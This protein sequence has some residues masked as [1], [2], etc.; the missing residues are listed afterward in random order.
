M[1]EVEQSIGQDRKNRC[2]PAFSIIHRLGGHA[3]VAL[4]I[5]RYGVQQARAMNRSTVYAWTR[6]PNP[7]GTGGTGGYIPSKHWPAIIKAARE[8]HGIELTVSDFSPPL[9]D[10]LANTA[11]AQ[12]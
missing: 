12:T 2:E 7:D 6:E 10:A 11:A 4:Y 1:T 3:Q 9:A 5:R 8:H